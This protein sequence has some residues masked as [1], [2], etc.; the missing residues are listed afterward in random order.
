M[1]TWEQPGVFLQGRWLVWAGV[2]R[3]S[4]ERAAECNISE[5]KQSG[6]TFLRGYEDGNGIRGWWLHRGDKS[7]E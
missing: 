6:R 2:R 3:A 4:R 1:S 5:S 7:N